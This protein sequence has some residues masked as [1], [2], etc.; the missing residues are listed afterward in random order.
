MMKKYLAVAV[1]V[2]VFTSVNQLNVFAQN[3]KT[4]PANVVEPA[5]SV[6]VAGKKTKFG[7]ADLAK[8]KRLT[9]NTKDHGIDA[10]F[11]GVAMADILTL[12]GVEFGE[13]L[14]GKR[15]N[16]YVIVEAADNYRA[17]YALAEFDPSF[18]DNVIILAD[19]RDG[20]A[21]PEKAA[22]WQIIVPNEK[23]GGRWVRQVISIK[24]I[25]AN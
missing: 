12:A 8:L 19:K 17:V 18:T 1:L 11:E 22:N 7:I 13:K 25:A 9:I 3:T 5:L 14:R 21:L 24:V 4:A 15:M 6:E 10:S 16:E 23:R 20:K 2:L